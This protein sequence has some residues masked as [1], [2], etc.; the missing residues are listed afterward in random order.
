M[1]E[2]YEDIICDVVVFETADVIKIS[3]AGESEGVI[4]GRSI[5]NP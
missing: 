1:K 5:T 4:G 2:R 3:G